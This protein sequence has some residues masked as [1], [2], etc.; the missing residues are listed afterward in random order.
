MWRPRL[1]ICVKRR[2]I[3]LASAQLIHEILATTEGSDSNEILRLHS[4]VFRTSIVDLQLTRVALD[5]L[6]MMRSVAV[7]IVLVD[8]VRSRVL[9]A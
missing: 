8:V 9:E 6:T 7:D 2:R 4:K 1:I 3:Q 5:Q